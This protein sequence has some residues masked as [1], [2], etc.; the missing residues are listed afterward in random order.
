MRTDQ[1]NVSITIPRNAHQGGN[2]TVTFECTRKGEQVTII[3]KTNPKHIRIGE[4]HHAVA[5]AELTFR[6]RQIVEKHHPE[7]D[8]FEEM[9]HVFMAIKAKII[10][11]L[12]TE[13]WRYTE[14]EIQGK[15]DKVAYISMTAETVRD[16]SEIT[17]VIP[18]D[19][20]E[21]FTE[22]MSHLCVRGTS[23]AFKKAMKTVTAGLEE[24]HLQQAAF[25]AAE[26]ELK[27]A[28]QEAAAA[29]QQDAH[30]MAA[31]FGSGVL[32]DVSS[33]EEDV[34]VAA[35]RRS[36]QDFPAIEGTPEKKPSA[37]AMGDSPPEE[38]VG[39][40]ATGESHRRSVSEGLAPN[41]ARRQLFANSAGGKHHR[42]GAS[43]GSALTKVVT[44]GFV[45]D[46]QEKQ[47]QTKREQREAAQRSFEALYDMSRSG[48]DA[49]RPQTEAEMIA[50]LEA[51]NAAADAK[52]AK[53]HEDR[54]AAESARWHQLRKGNVGVV[55]RDEGDLVRQGRNLMNQ[56]SRGGS[57]DAAAAPAFAPGS[58]AAAGADA[59]S[60]VPA[61]DQSQLATVVDQL[62][63]A[64]TAGKRMQSH[65]RLSRGSREAVE[66]N[67]AAFDQMARSFGGGKNRLQ[68]T[69]ERRRA[70]RALDEATV[71][72]MEED[73][74][75]LAEQRAGDVT[76]G[77]NRSNSHASG[78]RIGGRRDQ[79][80]PEGAGHR[81]SK[82]APCS[83][84]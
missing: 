66:R 83:I 6:G 69:G 62:N 30:E 24:E 68:A 80:A 72:Q 47:A 9:R 11:I 65:A 41:A 45:E 76:R 54:V 77:H 28:E 48:S 33:D 60:G 18:A 26:A 38:E 14:F 12:V 31:L 27:K 44:A 53:Q 42:R 19:Y 57:K 39:A 13:N 10:Q 43:E 2:V 55:L 61:F 35:G 40:Q 71:E 5:A 70:A 25:V 74:R 79:V 32:E 36:P 75:I 21:D 3:S 23:A 20:V 58:A 15:L 73:Q 49:D 78:F 7:S 16:D 63:A 29:A 67:A 50:R 8:L 51:A 4:D 52:L 1:A 59:A 56:K 34:A 37:E 64:K 82:S 17:L 81:R 84:M 22:H 46:Y